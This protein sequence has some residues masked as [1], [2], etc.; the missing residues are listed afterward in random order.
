MSFEPNDEQER[1][2]ENVKGI[3]LVDAGAGTG[4]TVTITERYKKLLDED[5]I[6]PEDLLLMTFTNNAA[7]R[8]KEK[9]ISKS[10]YNQAELRYA[11]VS[12]FHSYCK[13]IVDSHGFNIPQILGIEDN[14]STPV[15]IIENRVIEERKFSRFFEHFV[16]DHTEYNNFY[17]I[18][19]DKNELLHLIKSLA[20]KGIIPTMKGWFKK[21]EEYLDGNIEEFRKI[22]REVNA[23][24]TGKSGN[25]TNSKL[26]GRFRY[27]DKCFEPGTPNEI[28]VRGDGS[29]KQ[30]HEKYFDEAFLE[31][32]KKL[33]E[34][35][36]D[37][38]FEYVKYCLS[39]NYLN[40]SF[41]M[42]FAFVILH[43]KHELRDEIAFEYVMIDEFQ[44]T[45][46]IQ[47]K[48]TMLLSKSNNICVVGDWKQSIYGFQDASIEN[49]MNFGDRIKKYKKELN[50]DYQRIKYSVEKIEKIEL[51]D[52]YRSTQ[53]ILDFSKGALFLRGN[54]DEEIDAEKVMEKVVSLESKKTLGKGEIEAFCSKEEKKAI[55][56]K[57]EKIV[58]N[59]NYTIKENE[60][61]RKLRYSDIAILTRTRRFGLEIQKTSHD[62]GIP[63]AY[64]GGIELFRTDPAIILLAWVRILQ[65]NDSR[66]GWSVVLEQAGYNLTETKI[67]LDTKKYPKDMIDFKNELVKLKEISTVSRKVFDR[68]GIDDGF[69]ARLTESLEKI[70]RI[71]YM[72]KSEIIGFIGDCIESGQTEDVDNSLDENVV[73]IQTMHSS[74]GLEYPVVFISDINTKR[75]PSTGSDKSV[76][77]YDNFAGIRQKKKY[78]DEGRPYIYDNWGS[79]ILLKCLS[80]KYDEERR[81]MYVA[82][83]RAMKYLYISADSER[84]STFFTDLKIE[85]KDI[86]PKLKKSIT[87][88]NEPNN[89]IAEK[90]KEKLPLKIPVQAITIHKKHGGRGKELGNKVHSFAEKIGK[91]FEAE[92]KNVDEKNVKAFLDSLKGKKITEESMFLPVVVNGR[93]M[94]LSGRIDLLH[95]IGEK[96][97]IIDYKT[98]KDPEVEKEYI[99]QLSVYYQVLKEVFP[100]KEI[101]A[102]IFYTELGELK[103]IKPLSFDEIKKLIKIK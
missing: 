101:K 72:N 88:S 94:V 91:G 24:Q 93:Q 67:I 97:E 15:R 42:M 62:Y 4:K 5:G 3:Y 33:K 44:D 50:R 65:Y 81:L 76:I 38:Y 26:M 58:D 83:T 59:E 96:I 31:N 69:S 82:M 11:P 79:E 43:E 99:K 77:V 57:I 21:G 78:L 102:F 20:V 60:K 70:F 52:S 35:V 100:K 41:L 87:E 84:A 80:G 9:I 63:A 74:K 10:N 55:L 86:E 1:I 32:R 40:F 8:M 53:E 85:K 71:S 16:K 30:I 27:R 47:F 95:F 14:L 61:E 56:E 92:P 48:L 12:T 17:R 13:R 89:L 39:K 73:T 103:E 2:I 22:F 46:E 6:K 45:N 64:E 19:H 54:N 98:Y 90:A 37:L 34:F 75:F 68:Y 51:I 66:R 29:Q 7:E 49:I 18:L 25:E 36:H 23:P 28:D